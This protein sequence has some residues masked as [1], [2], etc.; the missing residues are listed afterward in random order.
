MPT[1]ILFLKE[2]A[3][4]CI[5]PALALSTR[6]CSE[7]VPSAAVWEERTASLLLHT[8]RESMDSDV[9]GLRDFAKM[10]AQQAQSELKEPDRVPVKKMHTNSPADVAEAR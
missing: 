1:S 8:W 2:F 5:Q 10:C 9:H 6:T 4:E 7:H 3:K